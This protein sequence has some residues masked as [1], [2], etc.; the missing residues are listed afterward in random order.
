MIKVV[1]ALL[2]QATPVVPVPPVDIYL[3]IGQ[4]IVQGVDPTLVPADM[5]PIPRIS[6]WA[7][8]GTPG[9]CSSEQPLIHGTPSVGAWPSRKFA[10]DL[11]TET[12]CPIGLVIK[13]VSGSAI[14]DWSPNG[15]YLDARLKAQA[16][17]V[18]GGAP[19]RAAIW[20][21]GLRDARFDVPQP[22]TALAYEARLR[23]LL[24]RIRTDFGQPQLKLVVVEEPRYLGEP[25]Y[26][27]TFPYLATV[28]AAKALVCSEM[29]P[30]RYVTAEGL[31]TFQPGAPVAH[32]NR[33][34]QV[35]P[36]GLGHR[37]AVALIE[38]GVTPSCPLVPVE[39]MSFEVQ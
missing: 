37:V 38:L 21:Q 3:H 17:E 1:F 39:L 36:S 2:L 9:W 14:A 12:P 26:A 31:A 6:V 20:Q 19:I 18:A 16:A 22:A 29:P 13:S 25:P 11:L 32:P 10:E 33:E 23:E 8:D 35:G 27:G 5:A 15:Y 34:S 30:C 24:A 28:E 4:S 7:C